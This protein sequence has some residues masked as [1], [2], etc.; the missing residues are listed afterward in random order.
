M[1]SIAEYA[2]QKKISYQAVNQQIKRYQKELKGHIRKQGRTRFLDDFA[3]SF[4]DE[5]RKENPITIIQDGRNERIEELEQQVSSLTAKVVELQDRLI[6]SKDTIEQLQADNIK[7]LTAA[8]ENAQEGR[9]GPEKDEVDVKQGEGS[10]GQG[11]A[12]EGLQEREPD[13]TDGEAVNPDAPVESVPDPEPIPDRVP[14]EPATK[15]NRLV[16]AWR[17]LWGKE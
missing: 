2:G 11:E 9:E 4:L 13:G 8:A 15:G 12:A 10:E 5:R 1:V 14:Q 6:R 17:V 16:R 7:L 3:V